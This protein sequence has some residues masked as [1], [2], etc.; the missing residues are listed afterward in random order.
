MSELLSARRLFVLAVLLVVAAIAAALYLQYAVG[1]APCPLCVLQR[2]GF[3]LAAI[4]ALLAA[5]AARGG[6]LRPALGVLAIAG[7]LA[8][9]GVA[10]WHT[11]LLA[12]PP[13]SL[14]CGRPFEWFN[15]DFP[16]IVWLPRL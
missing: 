4:L 1:V 2:M 10:A 14:G 7:S 3:L 15:D 5:L 13:E 11:W 8:G 16:L 9:G 12:H 6:R